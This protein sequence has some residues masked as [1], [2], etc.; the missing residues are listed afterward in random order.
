MKEPGAMGSNL[1]HVWK[2]Q[3][4]TSHPAVSK[5]RR[6]ALSYPPLP[7]SWDRRPQTLVLV[8]CQSCALGAVTGTLGGQLSGSWEE[9][10]CDE[11]SV[12]VDEEGL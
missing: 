5:G 3:I 1:V 12:S 2:E 6:K 4:Y 10:G 7:P 11:F 8:T 9:G